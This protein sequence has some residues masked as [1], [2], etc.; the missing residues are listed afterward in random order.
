MGPW[1]KKT[2]LAC[3]AARARPPVRQG[4]VDGILRRWRG[5][6]PVR[7][8]ARAPTGAGGSERWGLCW[9]GA[10]RREGV[11]PFEVLTGGVVV[12]VCGDH[13]WFASCFAWC[14]RV[15]WG[16]DVGR[17]AGGAG[18]GTIYKREMTKLPFAGGKYFGWRK[19]EETGGNCKHHNITPKKFSWKPITVQQVPG[20][21]IKFPYYQFGLVTVLAA[22]SMRAYGERMAKGHASQVDRRWSPKTVRKV[23]SYKENFAYIGSLV[24]SSGKNNLHETRS[25]FNEQGACR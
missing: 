25:Q 22:T 16:A 7:C 24:R 20:A 6:P 21:S 3:L 5:R 2:V 10:V 13:L 15:V 11:P 12:A 18:W 19:W 4:E 23:G 9:Y 17:A 1:G 8:L 14:V